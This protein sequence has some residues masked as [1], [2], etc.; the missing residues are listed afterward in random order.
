[1]KIPILKKQIVRNFSVAGVFAVIF[2][3]V[4]YYYSHRKSSVQTKIDAINSETSQINVELSDL[5]SKTAEITK[6]KDMWLKISR[7][8][9]DTSG[10]KIDEIKESLTKIAGKYSITDQN[11]KLSLPEVVKGGVFDRKTIGVM[12]TTAS[13]T[14]TAASDVKAMMF[15]NEFISSLKGYPVITS[16]SIS[17]SKDYSNEDL[18][19]LSNGT[20]VGIVGGKIDFYWYIYKEPE[21]KE[22]EKPINPSAPSEINGVENKSS[23]TESMNGGANAPRP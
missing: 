23:A 17:K 13:I 11:I 22:N 21:K 20:S 16:F 14:F 12:M 10:I 6:Y 7:S 3:G 15:I 2:I 4:F 5:Q 8:Q 9:K 1:M 18:I 19:K